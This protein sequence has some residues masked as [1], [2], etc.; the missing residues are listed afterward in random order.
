MPKDGDIAPA[1]VLIP[2]SLAAYCTTLDPKRNPD[3][4]LNVVD[5]LKTRPMHIR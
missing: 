2:Y 5:P 3:P 4:A 1:E